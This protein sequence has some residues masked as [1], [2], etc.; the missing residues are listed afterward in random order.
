MLAQRVS[1]ALGLGEFF[2]SFSPRPTK[3][4]GSQGP[5]AVR[6]PFSAQYNNPFLGPFGNQKGRASGRAPEACRP[7][8]NRK[9]LQTKGKT[10]QQPAPFQS[11]FGKTPPQPYCAFPP[12]SSLRSQPWIRYL[13]S[14]S[15]RLPCIETQ[16]ALR[17]GWRKPRMTFPHLPLRSLAK[18]LDF[19]A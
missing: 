2:F 12:S 18:Q 19:F 3:K 11:T 5:R 16:K 10:W 6:L 14:V 4:R 9:N 1:H 17:P 15:C 13:S 8:R 7:R